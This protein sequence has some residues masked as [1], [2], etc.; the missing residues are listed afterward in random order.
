LS[1]LPHGP[2]VVLAEVRQQER[3]PAARVLGVAAHHLESR[4]LDL[5]LALGLFV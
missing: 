1:Q 5:A 2:G 4:A 3:A